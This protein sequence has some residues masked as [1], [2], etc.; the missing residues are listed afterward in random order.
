MVG[1]VISGSGP[2]GGLFVGPTRE[3]IHS[4]A[5]VTIATPGP[6]E[7]SD[8]IIHGSQ[9]DG[10]TFVDSPG[11]TISVRDLRSMSNAGD[12]IVPR[13]ERRMPSPLLAHLWCS[14]AYFESFWT[15]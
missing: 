13:E 4:R 12:A 6:V 10:A 15:P 3:G 9:G 11:R 1:V 2:G 14:A 7:V 5:A 8:T